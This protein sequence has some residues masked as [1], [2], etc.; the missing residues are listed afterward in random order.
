[1]AAG[2]PRRRVAAT[3]EPGVGEV[4]DAAQRPPEAAA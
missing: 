4:L 1:M 2:K 3:Q